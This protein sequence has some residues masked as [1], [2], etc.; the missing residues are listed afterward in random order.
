MSLLA[1]LLLPPTFSAARDFSLGGFGSDY[2]LY[3]HFFAPEK[4]YL[5]LDRTYYTSGETIWFNGILQ[6][7]SDS[8]EAAC[9]NFI[10]VELQDREGKNILRV[11]AKRRGFGFP[12]NLLLPETLETGRYT[13]RA[14]TLSQIDRDPEYMFNQAVDVLGADGRKQRQAQKEAGGGIDV[15][16]YPEGGRWFSGNMSCIA[17]KAM[18]EEGRS[19]DLQAAVVDQDDNF[20][21]PAATVH[22]G[23]GKVAIFPREGSTYSLKLPDGRKIRLPEPS[24]EGAAISLLT[25]PGRLCV[26]VSGADLSKSSGLEGKYSL[27]IRDRDKMRQIGDVA[28]G[29]GGRQFIIGR[30]LLAGGINHLLLVNS[31]GKIVSERMFFVF[32]TDSPQCA[33]KPFGN[34]REARSPLVARL[35]LTDAAGKPLGGNCSV[36]VV[37]GSLASHCQDDNLVSYMRL[38]GELRGKINDPDW[39]F[40]PSVPLRERETALD[41]LM[42][43]QGWTYYKLDW[44]GDK[45]SKMDLPGHAREYVQSIRGRID[46][47]LGNKVPRKFAMFVWIPQQKFTTFVQ[48]EEGSTFKMDSLDFSENTGFLVKVI[49]E[50]GGIDYI[51]K[52]A[53]DVFASRHVYLPAAGHSSA[54]AVEDNIPLTVETITDTLQAAVVTAD[55]AFDELLGGHSVSPSELELYRDRSLIDYVSMKAPSFRYNQ[56]GMYN[57]RNV[58]AS[59]G[60]VISIDEEGN[61]M[62]EDESSEGDVKLVV[63]GSVQDWWMFEDISLESISAISISKISDSFYGAQGGVVSIKLRSGVRIERSSETE[64]SLAYFVPLGYQVPDKF[65]APRYDRGDVFDEFDHRN[66]IYW[67]PS[68]KI[69]GGN[70]VLRFCNTDQMDLPYL[71]RAEGIT[72]DGRPFSASRLID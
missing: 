13:L 49:R 40:D 57:T 36:S 41:L 8:T 6:N 71:L 32:D 18:D 72:S 21:C 33:V 20:I 15:S 26:S 27:V 30:A 12:G 51:P 50:G 64:P 56:G 53:G 69:E 2:R 68:V 7:A 58:R 28:L 52:W 67:N 43:V 48:V 34:T 55:D 9:S 42:M 66:T 46:R 65:Y 38:S 62:I 45:D 11:K 24:P 63:D 22:D 4:L 44:M 16:F 60:S 35:S 70:A 25:L 37:R 5:H 59:S 19:V 29:G 54:V 47:W 23:M 39:Y 1:V 10:Y 17:F 31:E 14:Y 3:T 61:E